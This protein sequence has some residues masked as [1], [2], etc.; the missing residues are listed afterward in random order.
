LL[1][2]ARRLE[3]RLAAKLA[4]S[5]HA[6]MDA[7]LAQLESRRVPQSAELTAGAG[8][9]PA[10]PIRRGW[11]AVCGNLRHHGQT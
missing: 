9:L 5:L 2:L 11:Q 1:A 4:L 8:L 6:Q 10:R 7:F 3:H